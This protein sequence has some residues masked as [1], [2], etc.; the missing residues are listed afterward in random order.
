VL[1][2][3]VSLTFTEHVVHI[4]Q[5]TD[6]FLRRESQEM[7]Q[8]KSIPQNFSLS[9]VV[10]FS[11]P[12]LTKPENA[13][14]TKGSV[15]W[16]LGDDRGSGGQRSTLGDFLNCPSCSLC[17]R[18]HRNNNNNNRNNKYDHMY[19]SFLPASSSLPPDPQEHL[20]T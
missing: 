3:E 15:L 17:L 5:H 19:P 7:Y 12:A 20:P 14:K 4:P 2:P 16:G 10:L 6:F 11:P 18:I 13:M 9:E 8:E 1:T